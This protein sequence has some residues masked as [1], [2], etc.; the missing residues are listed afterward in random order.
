MTQSHGRAHE[1]NGSALTGEARCV[2]RGRGACARGTGTNRSAPSG[3][4]R[5][6][7]RGDARASASTDRRVHLLEGECGHAGLGRVGPTGRGWA[8]MGFPFSFEF[9]IA[10]IFI[11]SIE[12]NSNQTTNSNSNISNM[13]I[14]QKQSLSSA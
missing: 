13:C 2:G 1:G 5:G 8:E 9:I 3:R 12:F 10:F 7:E 4:G 11:F 14:N 6:R